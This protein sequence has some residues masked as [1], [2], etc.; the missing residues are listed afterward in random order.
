MMFLAFLFALCCSGTAARNSNNSTR[1]SRWPD[2]FSVPFNVTIP[3]FKATKLPSRLYYDWSEKRQ[4]VVHDKCPI[5]QF[6]SCKIVFDST[7]MHVV[8]SLFPRLGQWSPRVCC[9]LSNLG[10]LRP[11][12][13]SSFAFSEGETEVEGRSVEKWNLFNHGFYYLDSETG[14]PVRFEA[15]FP[16]PAGLVW[17]DFTGPFEPLVVNSTEVQGG[18]RRGGV[19]LGSAGEEE[20]GGLPEVGPV[21]IVAPAGVFDRPRLCLPKCPGGVAGNRK[22]KIMGKGRGDA[23]RSGRMSGPGDGSGGVQIE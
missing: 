3:N 2:Q 7:G 5:L 16:Q 19:P 23:G 21:G 12:L 11:D 8:D 22:G 14:E 17:W 6:T 1:P 9:K 15:E 4:V 13:F 18:E 10:T 20:E